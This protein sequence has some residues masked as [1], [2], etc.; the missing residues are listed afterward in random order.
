MLALLYEVAVLLQKV[1]VEIA[2]E[3]NWL[4]RNTWVKSSIS[5]EQATAQTDI[6]RALQTEEHTHNKAF[7]MQANIK[8]CVEFN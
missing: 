5:V 4:G 2:V 6:T 3:K 1:N 8:W 7:P